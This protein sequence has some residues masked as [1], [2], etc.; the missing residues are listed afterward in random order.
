MLVSLT[1]IACISLLI[2][3][4]ENSLERLLHH[5]RSFI[6]RVEDKPDEKKELKEEEEK[7]FKNIEVKF[8]KLLTDTREKLDVVV[9]EISESLLDYMKLQ[10][11]E[12]KVTTWKS[13][14]IPKYEQGND[15]VLTELAL[16]EAIDERLSDVLLEWEKKEKM[17]SESTKQVVGEFCLGYENIEEQLDISER[18]I[19][20]SNEIVDE[21]VLDEFKR[22]ASITPLGPMAKEQFQISFG[23]THGS[24]IMQYVG[25][26]GTIVESLASGPALK[27][28]KPKDKPVA[29]S[30]ARRFLENRVTYVQERAQNIYKTMCTKEVMEGVI[31][32]Q[33]EPIVQYINSTEET[34]L[35]IIESN[36][37]L[38]NTIVEEKR[39]K[40]TVQN[41]YRPVEKQVHECLDELLKFGQSNIL[42]PDYAMADFAD[43]SFDFKTTSLLWS[44]AAKKSLKSPRLNVT[45]M[46][47]NQN[48][49]TVMPTE[50]YFQEKNLR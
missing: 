25:N 45:L 29:S 26:M 8:K 11:T 48:G 38:L 44:L 24:D 13:T 3:W 23:K 27:S 21:R 14:D 34:T 20:F 10:K 32:Q 37:M 39:A 30:D 43:V 17:V 33:V 31:R 2:R 9:E 16:D 36:C 12:E 6:K 18:K 46:R 49:P 50:R 1:L 41:L 40:G 42:N 47:A 35:E 22:K 19:R 7:H 15:W 4:L 5:I 28:F